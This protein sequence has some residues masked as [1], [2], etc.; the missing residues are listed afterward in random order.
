[1]CWVALDRGI[2]LAEACLRRAPLARWRRTRGAIRRAIDRH[3]VDRSRGVF[4][5]AFGA[6]DL[7]ASVLRLPCLG[8]VP[9]DDPRMTATVDA[10]REELAD[11][12]LLRR[13]RNDDGLSGS[14][15]AFLPCTFWLVECLARQGRRDEAERLY[16]DVA[17]TA[18]DAGLFAEEFDVKRGELMG[19]YPQALTHLSH[20]EAI[21]AL[22]AASP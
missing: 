15:C 9:Y 22:D 20:I 17:Q 7:D 5:Q 6:R 3:G 1:M 18:N 11:G 19:N 10:I 14:E 2:A 16:A 21:L 4:V 13:Y 12:P 8:F